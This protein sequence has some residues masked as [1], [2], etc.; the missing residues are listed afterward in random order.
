MVI[1]SGFLWTL[2]VPEMP[3]A[4]SWSLVLLAA[5]ATCCSSD[6]AGRLA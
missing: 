1:I 2:L 3:L 6:C 4:R 5:Y